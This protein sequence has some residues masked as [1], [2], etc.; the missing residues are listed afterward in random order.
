MAKNYRYFLLAGLSGLLLALAY[1]GWGLDLGWLAWVGL[2]PLFWSLNHLATGYDR[3]QKRSFAF[4]FATGLV[5]FL[6]IFRW[7][8]SIYPLDSLG[9]QSKALSFV[10]ILLMY[11]FSAAGM[12]I[13]WG[14]FGLTF[15]LQRLAFRK[16]S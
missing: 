14:L 15:S 3:A 1:P 5:Y 13:F 8:W 10:V 12:A 16:K 9:I 11:I 7:F 6:I 4:G 2:I